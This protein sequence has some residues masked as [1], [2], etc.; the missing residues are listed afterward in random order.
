MK[1]LGN[2]NAANND[3]SDNT[4]KSKKAINAVMIASRAPEVNNR[5]RVI[6]RRISRNLILLRS[7]SAIPDAASAKNSKK[8]PVTTAPPRR[9]LPD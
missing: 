4:S 6:S 2:T 9:E 1:R 3:T 5:I 8:S 7:P